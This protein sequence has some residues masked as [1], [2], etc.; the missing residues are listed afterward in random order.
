MTLSHLTW[1]GRIMAAVWDRA[2]PGICPQG[3]LPRLN[4]YMGK[5]TPKRKDYVMD[6]PVAPVGE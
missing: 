1:V 4:F 2:S 5:N 3:T 6:K